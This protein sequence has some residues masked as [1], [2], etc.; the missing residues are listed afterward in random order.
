M[1]VVILGRILLVVLVL[2]LLYSLFDIFKEIYRRGYLQNIFGDIKDKYVQRQK[3][4]E[5]NFLLEGEKEDLSF[6]EKI[7]LLLDRS[8]LH[9]Y[10]TFLT[11]EILIVF[12]IVVAFTI[13]FIFQK[14]SG[15]LVFSLAVFFAVIFI[16]YLA[17]NQLAKITYD[18]IDDQVLIYINILEN[19]SSSNSDIVEIMGKALPYMR[20]P[21]KN[22]S[23]QF[24]YECKRGVPIVKAFKNFE[25]KIESYRFK[26]LLKNLE[27]CSKYEANYKEIL[28]KSRIIM[29]NYFVEKEK[30]RKEVRNGRL[31]I[32]MTMG[33]GVVLFKLVLGF[34]ENMYE[35]L[36]STFLGNVILGYN[37]FVL[38]FGVFKFIT[39]DKLNY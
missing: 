35:Q 18:R 33:M 22:Y 32:I 31:A 17:L 14:I 20:E 21:L 9:A 28:S 19:L 25:N 29:K 37:L 23:S 7:D 16:V 10:M 13:A 38:M 36:K 26:Q 30:R 4:R 24:V 8:G 2:T 3:T 27:V 15:L 11:S 12:T 39:L 1:A 6:I 34:N 5:I